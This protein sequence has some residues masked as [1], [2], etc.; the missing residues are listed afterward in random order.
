MSSQQY[1]IDA[2]SRHALFLDRYNTG[3]GREIGDLIERILKSLSGAENWTEVTQESFSVITDEIA[4]RVVATAVNETEFFEELYTKAASADINP[5][6]I[7]Y[8]KQAVL[9]TPFDT[10]PGGQQLSI[11]E[12][13]TSF[14]AGKVRQV[15]Q[16]I[17]DVQLEGGNSVDQVRR[18]RAL[19]PLARREAATIVRTANNAA[20][21]ISAHTTMINN[22][23]VV[24]GYQWVST[25]DRHTSN[26]C[27]ARDGEVYPIGPSSPKPPAHWGCRSVI[28][29]KVNPKYDLGADVSG[30]RPSVG[31]KGS[32]EV[33]S[34]RTTYGGWLKKQSAEFQN[35]V[36]GVS[37]AKLFRSGK[38]T[39]K[40]FVD[41][42][43][44]TYT[45]D[46]LAALN[47][48]AMG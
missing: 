24:D 4:N 40:D 34:G 3:V 22:V 31:S 8:L 14:G 47:D 32:A 38:L 35:E 6:N 44:R 45:L 25:L 2:T 27:I 41:D 26:V 19:I 13:L 42:T 7:D 9:E 16:A 23:D 10:K 18:V 5:V 28:I 15:Q 46:E 21:V 20:S 12:A 30:R 33:V 1:L 43:G 11:N 36:L 39:V 48:L 37:R 17:R 29:P